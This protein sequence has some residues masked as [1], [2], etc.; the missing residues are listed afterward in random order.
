MDT[1]L[2]YS[3]YMD[4]MVSFDGEKNTLTFTNSALG[5]AA[6]L[7]FDGLYHDGERVAKFSDFTSYE[8]SRKNLDFSHE[9]TV[10]WLH[11]NPVLSGAEICI[12][13]D[14]TGITFVVREIGHFE[15]RAG[16][17]ISH[18]ATEDCCS[19]STKENTSSVIH[20]SIGPATLLGDNAIYNRKTDSAFCIDGIRGLT[21]GY[22]FD[23]GFYSFT[24]KTKTEGVAEHIKFHVKRNILA[25]KY[26]I[27]YSPLK[28]RGKFDTPPAGWMTWY[29]VKFDACE[30][31]V[32]QNLDFQ[33][34]NLAPFGA[35][36]LWVDWEWCHRRYEPERDDGVNNFN[37]DPQK[38]P[39]GLGYIADKIKEQG[40]RPAVWI[41]FTNDISMTDFEREHPEVSLAHNDT[42]SGR[43]YYDIS[44]PNF[45]DGYL[46]KAVSQVKD[47]GYEAVKFD[48]LPN[49]INAH[50]QFHD[51]MYRPELTT[52]SAYRNMIS[53]TRQMLGEDVFMLSC[54]SARQV[55]LWGVGVFDSARVGPDLFAWERYCQ[56]LG[57]IRSFYPLH[58]NALMVDPDCVVL[59]DEYSTPEQAKS[60]LATVSM[61][62]LPLT[63]GDD[64]TALPGDRV[65]LLKRALPV[66][67]VRPSDLN[68]AVSD[69]VSQLIVQQIAMPWENYTVLGLQNLTD[70]PISR[71]LSLEADLRIPNGEY[72]AIDFFSGE[73]IPVCHGGLTLG[74]SPY[75]TRVV[76][77]RRR[78]DRPQILSTSRHLTQGAAEI[79]DTFFEDST[80]CITSELVG[81]DEYKVTVHVPD[82]FVPVDVS[83]GEIEEISDNVIVVRFT[84]EESGEYD[85][86]IEFVD[87]VNKED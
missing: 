81:G 22:D 18:G 48:T 51:K 14:P 44:H 29:A 40:I 10:R 55:I 4:Y 74:V 82:G 79:V 30:E 9:L 15:F 73:L 60:R 65:D 24:V 2:Y 7:L 78:L 13:T 77:V 66:M 75:D 86:D 83:Y 85:V 64:L 38:Y 23:T 54:G 47:W 59:R 41:G 16:G 53:R 20:S 17:Y 32:L 19:V 46:K 87:I 49:C 21:M 34:K 28:K 31:K 11:P 84:P 35:N 27:E 6:T 33:A 72:F 3:S 71:D 25:D 43:Y 57:R 8:V 52:Y 70:Q 80:L 58:N 12:T 5:A 37:P 26:H 50:E 76:A 56:T 67:K 1:K 45:L 68:P 36:T 42:W 39:H 62:G 69:E 61:L 63:F